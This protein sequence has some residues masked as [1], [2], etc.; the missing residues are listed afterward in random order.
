MRILVS[1]LYD[2][3]NGRADKIH[4]IH[5]HDFDL[6]DGDTFSEF[7]AI[8]PTLTNAISHDIADK[9]KSVAEVLDANLTGTDAQDACKLLVI[10]SLANIPN[11]TLG[12]AISETISNLCAPGRDIAKVK[13]ALSHLQTKAWY[14][15]TTRDGKLYFKNVQNLVAKLKSASENYNRETVLR[16]L[17]GFL[18]NSFTPQQKDCFQEILALSPIDEIQTKLR[19]DR[20]VLVLCEPHSS[21]GL[22]PDLKKFYDDLDFK[23]RILFLAGARQTLETLLSNSS[24]FKAINWILE[25]MEKEKVPEN[26]PQRVNATQMLD[27]IRLNLL[28]AARETFTT[29]HYPRSPG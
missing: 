29:L 25:E 23:N 9:G 6:N 17:R 24:E 21:G 13:D 12:L 27:K 1:R 3:K 11:A 4:L 8:N 7:T 26:D 22:H 16:E 28:S 20:T 14:L 10:A 19:Q 2:K 18:S 15:H 5:A